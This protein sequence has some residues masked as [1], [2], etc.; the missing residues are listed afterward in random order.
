[1]WFLLNLCF[2]ILT[3][4]STEPPEIVPF[5]FGIGAVNEGETSMVTCFVKKG[6]K[7]VS[8]TW[9][10]KGDVVTSDPD[11]VTTMLG[12]QASILTI[13]SVG[14]R[15]SGTY[16]CRATNSAGSVTHSA[17]LLVKGN[18]GYGWHFGT[19]SISKLFLIVSLF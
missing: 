8:I 6:D 12:T 11:M 5:N 9:S 18:R 17:E 19:V 3:C 1:M 4:D 7:P 16:T 13:A 10:L 2:A 14:Y 15:H